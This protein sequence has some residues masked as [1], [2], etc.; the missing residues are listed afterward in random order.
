MEPGLD[1]TSGRHGNE[2]V[3]ETEI[4]VRHERNRVQNE[5]MRCFSLVQDGLLSALSETSTT[6]SAPGSDVG[7]SLMES[8]RLRI[9][10][11]QRNDSQRVGGH[12]ASSSASTLP[13]DAD[14]D[15]ADLLGL[16]RERAE[17][18]HS[19][20]AKVPCFFLFVVAV[21]GLPSFFCFSFLLP[22]RSE[23]GIDHETIDFQD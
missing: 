3:D 4:P 1:D 6:S 13:T 12:G 19:D 17:P 15:A 22:P 5:S 7:A 21:S 18:D 23:L 16:K 8:G 14:A 10:L 20:S 9:L 2:D 11:M